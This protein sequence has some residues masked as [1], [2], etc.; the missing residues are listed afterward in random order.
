[1]KGCVG[2]GSTSEEAVEELRQNEI[3][4]LNAA[5]EY[6]IPIPA[7]Y[8]RKETKFSGKVSL[9]M[10]PLIHEDAYNNSKELG[11]SLNQY[12]NDAINEYNQKYKNQTYSS[13]Y[14]DKPIESISY[15]NIIDLKNKI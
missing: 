13:T 11:I 3:E 7:E 4:W 6:G 12:I 8:I 15:P 2:Q 5:K 1:M 9:R 10:S 14:S